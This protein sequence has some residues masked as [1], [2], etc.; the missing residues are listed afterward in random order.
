MIASHAAVREATKHQTRLSD[1]TTTTISASISAFQKEPQFYS[2]DHPTPHDSEEVDIPSSK[3]NQDP[4]AAAAA[5]SPQSCPTLCDPIDGNPPGSSVHGIFQART[6]E[7]VAISSSSG[8]S[9]PRD[10]THVSCILL[11]WPGRF[12]TTVSPGKPKLYLFK[13]ILLKAPSTLISKTRSLV[14][15]YTFTELIDN[16]IK[17]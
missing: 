1:W 3:D 12:F 17:I 8:S 10:Q 16:L 6:L 2:V 7:W 11:H 14:I 5:K 15:T 13:S 9:W 4:S